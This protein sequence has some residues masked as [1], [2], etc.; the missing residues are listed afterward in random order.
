[1]SLLEFVQPDIERMRG[2]VPYDDRRKKPPSENRRLADR[3]EG[4]RLNE[5]CTTRRPH[6]M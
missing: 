6:A 5:K 2:Q 4:I 1:M 3:R